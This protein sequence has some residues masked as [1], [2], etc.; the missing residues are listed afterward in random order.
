MT[1]VDMPRLIRQLAALLASGRTGPALWTALAVVADN[2][3]GAAGPQGP[4]ARDRP[5]LRLVAATERA[6]RLGLPT[7]AALRTACRQEA[8]S[9]PRGGGR[10][11]PGE[12]TN[13]QWNTWL[14]LAAC[15]EICEVSGAPVAAVLRRLA[16]RLE[17]MADAAA[18]RET[19]LAGPR[20]T[21]R[22]LTWLP[23][24]GLALGTA[25][26]VDP[27]GVLVGGPVGWG[28]LGAGLVLVWLGRWWSTTL[29]AAAT[30][31]T[32]TRRP[33][34]VRRAGRTPGVAW[35]PAP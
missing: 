13:A 32:A 28:C 23:F 26:G 25:M 14:E 6:S 3:Y 29:I 21:V 16:D 8:G 24:V 10:S 30:R 11:R 5:E 31:G 34:G 35:F 12:L 15:F 9:H 33:F 1:G 17:A 22:L 2:E 4:R 20:A 19:A 27:V 7:A 18:L